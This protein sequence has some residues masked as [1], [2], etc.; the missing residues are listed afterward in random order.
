MKIYRILENGYY[1]G[2]QEIPDDVTG[3]PLYTTRTAPPEIP[4]GKMG[5]WNG[6]GWDV[7][8]PPPVIEPAAEPAPEPAPTETNLAE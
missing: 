5:F 2:E 3:I 8:D 7:I 6:S 1:G 4:E